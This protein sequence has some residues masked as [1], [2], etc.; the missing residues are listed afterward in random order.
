MPS[1]SPAVAL[2]LRLCV[3]RR[4]LARKYHPP[5]RHVA[6]ELS[7]RGHRV[8]INDMSYI[9]APLRPKC[10]GWHP[11]W[12]KAWESWGAPNYCC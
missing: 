1:I 9:S 12:G 7:A 2:G 6:L 10:S 5:L 4:Y 3:C 8:K 11:E